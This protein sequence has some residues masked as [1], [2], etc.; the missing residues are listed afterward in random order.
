MRPNVIHRTSIGCYERTLAWLIEKYEGAFPTWLSPVQAM[1]IPISEKH[2]EYAKEILARLEAAGI[3][4]EADMR[5]EK[6]GYKIR[7][8]Q[9]QKIPYML[10]VGDKEAEAGTVSLRSR[11]DGDEGSMPVDEFISKISEEIRSRSL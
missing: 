5:N 2:S 7:E 9:L 10:V 3:R 8:A 11:K 4:A 1:I 6:M